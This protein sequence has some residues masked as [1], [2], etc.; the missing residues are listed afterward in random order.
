MPT[1]S[2]FGVLSMLFSGRCHVCGTQGKLWNKKPEVWQC[3]NCKSVFS[4]FG[5]VVETDAEQEDFWS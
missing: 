3:P 2:R 1:G 4:K 5:L